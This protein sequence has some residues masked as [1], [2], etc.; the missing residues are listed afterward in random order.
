MR[1]RTRS[2]SVRTLRP[3]TVASP[4]LSGS[5]PVSILMT[6]VFPLPLG[7]RKPKISPLATAKLTLFTAVNFPNVRT[8][9]RAEMAGSAPGPPPFVFAMVPLTRSVSALEFHI[10]SHSRQNVMCRIIDAH[11]HAEH[12]M[13]PFFPR[14]HIARQKFGLLIDLFNQAFKRLASS[15]IHGDFGL[16]ANLYAVD[17]GFR[18]VDAHVNLVAFKQSGD[19]RVRS[20]QV[21]R[22]N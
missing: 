7:P 4:P 2:A 1:S 16:V 8:S 19:G 9:P 21:A 20:N 12:L 10:R 18:N 17:F 22:A 3:S 11:F 5:R 13:H 14:L 6:V 15:G